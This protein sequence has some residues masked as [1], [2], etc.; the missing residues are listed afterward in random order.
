MVSF[1]DREQVAGE[2]HSSTGVEISFIS[3]LKRKPEEEIPGLQMILNS[4]QMLGQ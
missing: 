2:S 4:S 3:G 1:Q